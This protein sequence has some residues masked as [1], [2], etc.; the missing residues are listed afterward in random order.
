MSDQKYKIPVCAGVVTY[1][2]DI[3]MLSG[4]IAALRTQVDEI[5]IFDNGSKNAQDLEQ[6][7]NKYTLEIKYCDANLGI[8]RALNEL[9]E[10]AEQ[11]GYGWIVTMDQDSICDSNMVYYL[12]KYS[13]NEKYGIIAPRVEFR[14]DR[15]LILSTKNTEKETVSINACITSGSLTN[16]KAWKQIG[17]FDEW[18]FIDHVDNE[19]C[20][21]LR[22]HGYEIIRVNSAVMYQRAGEMHY[23]DLP[24]GKK[25]LLPYY[26][27]FRNYYI[28]RNTVFYLRK[29]KNHINFRHELLTFIYAQTVKILFELKRISSIKSTYRGV[30]DGFK[31]NI[32]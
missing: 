2:P 12:L 26:S 20:T 4:N 22:V 9:C 15:E 32:E 13:D 30:I 29:Y 10:T 8:S 28:C 19:F 18:M 21:N 31:K 14:S 6:L 24:F 3:S 27:P 1:N 7:K 11:K 5:F 25:L 16:L 17:G 23:L